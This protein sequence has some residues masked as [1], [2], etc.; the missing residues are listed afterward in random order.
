MLFVFVLCQTE[1]DYGS[2]VAEEETRRLGGEE[3]E[4]IRGEK[5]ESRDRKRQRKEKESNFKGNGQLPHHRGRKAFDP[6]ADEKRVIAT[7]LPSPAK[8]RVF[9][10]K[11]QTSFVHPRPL[12]P[13]DP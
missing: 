7:A 9:S 13:K 3:K 5:G 11:K 4:E 12:S 10:R 6:R 8:A 1:W 2:S